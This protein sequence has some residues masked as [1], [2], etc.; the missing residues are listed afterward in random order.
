MLAKF[1]PDEMLS[2]IERERINFTLAVPTMIYMLLDHPKLSSFDT[3]SLELM[4]YGG[5]AMSPTRLLEAIRQFGP[6]FSQLYGQVECYPITVMR[7][8]DHDPEKPELFEA[9][10]FPTTSSD[11]TL[12]DGDDQEVSQGERGEI[13]VRSPIAMAHYWRDPALTSETLAGSWL[14]TGDIARADQEGRLYIVDRKKDMIVS[15]GFNVYPREIEDVLSS[16]PRVQMAA[17]IGIPD[18]KWGEAARAFV[19]LK[20]G[21][22]ECEQELLQ[23]IK[24]QKGSVHVPKVL[25]F[26]DELPLTAVGKVDKKVL[27][28]PFWANQTRG[29]G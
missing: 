20:A 17:V 24:A 13:C 19:V 29:V 2:T 25:E 16:D 14:R 18:A 27:R 23:L 11:V 15:G 12:R 6:V 5:S 28:A 22:P 4:L 9:C 7:K 3:S 21:G 10:G 1:D 26:V 8:A